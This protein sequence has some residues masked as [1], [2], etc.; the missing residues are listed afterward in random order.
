MG[1]CTSSCLPSPHLTSPALPTCGTDEGQ[2]AN[3]FW[4]LSSIDAGN[5]SPHG[6]AHQMKGPS[7]QLDALHKL[8]G[9]QKECVRGEE[10]T[11]WG[12]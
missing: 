12:H 4:V 1:F 6:S 5:V 10:A 9:E 3:V 8:A 2:A 7:V 11:A